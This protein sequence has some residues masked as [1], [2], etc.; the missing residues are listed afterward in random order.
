MGITCNIFLFEPLKL[1]LGGRSLHSNEEVELPL[2]N[3]CKARVQF[4]GQQ[5]F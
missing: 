3:G 2:M 5:N 4:L 1:H